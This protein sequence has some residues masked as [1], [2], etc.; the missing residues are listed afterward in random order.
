MLVDIERDSKIGNIRL[1]PKGDTPVIQS[2]AYFIFARNNPV[3][4]EAVD[5]A[6]R[7][8]KADGTLARIYQEAVLDY[9]ANH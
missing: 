8:M 3:L 7:D 9:Y 2:G 4:K 5:G 6:L 1:I